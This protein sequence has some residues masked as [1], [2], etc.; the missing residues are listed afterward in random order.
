MEFET[1]EQKIDAIKKWWQENGKMVIAGLIL[2]GAL[3]AGWR[4]YQDYKIKHAEQ[5]SVLYETVLQAAE[6]GGEMNEQQTRV[7]ELMAE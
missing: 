1:E 4:F 6:T 2:G 7:N 3:I 5:A